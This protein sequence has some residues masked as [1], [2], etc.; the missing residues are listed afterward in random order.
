M[1]R[2]PIHVG[3]GEI[4]HNALNGCTVVSSPVKGSYSAPI[5]ARQQTTQGEA[6]PIVETVTTPVL[7]CDGWLHRVFD[8]EGELIGEAPTL[9]LARQIARTGKP[10]PAPESNETGGGKRKTKGG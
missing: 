9:G 1:P 10:I 7:E 8:A 2:K 4:C 3:Q 6:G 5:E